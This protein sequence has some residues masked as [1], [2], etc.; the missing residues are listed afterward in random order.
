MNRILQVM[1][2]LAALAL[3]ALCQNGRL[4]PDDQREF[5]K[6][7]AKWVNDSLRTIVMI[8]IKMHARCRTSCS[9]TTFRLT[10][11][12]IAS[13]AMAMGGRIAAI[14]GATTT[15]SAGQP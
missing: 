4:S 8:S 11:P 12:T 9:A 3:P 6:A 7:Y 15:L 13:P 5:D 1:A 14:R 2:L 10:C